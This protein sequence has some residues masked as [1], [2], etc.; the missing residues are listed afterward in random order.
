MN[1]NSN[2]QMDVHI[3]LMDFSK[4]SKLSNAIGTH[5]YFLLFLLQ[6]KNWRQHNH[7]WTQTLSRQNENYT[8][9]ILLSTAVWINLKDQFEYDLNI[10]CLIS[11]CRPQVWRMQERMTQFMPDTLDSAN[12]FRI[13]SSF[14]DHLCW[15][16]HTFSSRWI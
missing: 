15:H 9:C 10:M 1:W 12:P 2:G 8:I 13:F 11:C 4:S 16:P 3:W 6:M 5:L 7:N 14:L